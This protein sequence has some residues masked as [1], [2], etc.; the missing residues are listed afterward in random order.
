MKDIHEILQSTFGYTSFRGQQEEIIQHTLEGNDSLVI[1]PTGGGKSLC[2]QIP[3]LVNSGLT[4]VVSPLIALMNDQVNALRQHGV[5]AAALHSNLS[6]S[7]NQQVITAVETGNLNLLYVSPEKLMSLHFIDWLKTTSVCL[8]A[9]DEAHCVSVWGNDFRPDYVQLGKLKD[10]FT[11]VPTIALTATADANTQEDIIKQLRLNGEQ[12]FVSSFERK[13]ITTHCRP[14]QGRIQQI[15]DF[16]NTKEG[17]AGI[18]YCLSR[19]STESVAEKLQKKGLKAEA[20]HAGLAPHKRSQIQRHF[21]DDDI[22]IICA[23]IAFGMGIDKPN[24]RYVIHYN[25][26]KNIEGYYQEIGRAGRDGEE[27]EALLFYSWGDKLNLQ[28][29]IDD[30]SSHETFKQVQSVKLDRMW[31][32]AS[33]VHCRTN[34]VLN[35]FG[36]YKKVACGH[37]DNCLNPPKTIDGTTFAQMALSAIVRTKEQV[38]VNTLIDILRGSHKAEIRNHGYDRVK[39]FGVGRQTDFLT[40]S[41][42]ITQLINQGLIQ[43]DLTDNSRLKLTPLSNAVLKSEQ[44]VPLSQFVKQTFKT[45]PKPNKKITLNALDIDTVLFDK[46]REWRIELA[47]ENNVPA[48]VILNDRTLKHLASAKPTTASQ[49]LSIEGIGKAKQSRFGKALLSII[50]DH[51]ET[52]TP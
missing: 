14:G 44:E 18:I 2:Y 28:K 10:H 43:L 16:I 21:Q 52:L 17:Q 37:C 7:E 1:M 6:S 45:T 32:F 19:K 24:I 20:Y 39:T 23:T 36:E 5:Q 27:S 30:A 38:G 31:Q 51:L 40:W 8:F 22:D 42:Y 25:L 50:E 46:L 15:F 33:S 13:N 9:I 49:L 48:F 47:K 29:F 34:T 35:Y 4:V 26:P 41:H 3:A 11:T 12:K